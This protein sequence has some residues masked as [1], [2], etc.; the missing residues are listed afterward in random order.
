VSESEAS[1]RAEDEQL[2]PLEQWLELS[3][4]ERQLVAFEI[5]DG[6]VQQATGALMHLQ[7]FRDLHDP[8]S[9]EA[10]KAFDSAIGLLEESLREA[11]RLMA[12][13]RPPVLEEAGVV[14]AMDD[15]VRDANQ[16]EEAQIDFSHAV[17]FDRLSSVL[18]TT[19]FRIAQ[20]G[21]T[22][23]CRHSQSAKV[24]ISLVQD[25]ERIHLEVQDWGVGFDPEAVDP[26]RFGLRGIRERAR[27]LGG[28]A[29][30]ETSPGQGTRLA[31][32]LPL[33]RERD[34]A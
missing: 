14:A 18:E 31:V 6:F 30:I 32:E 8:E 4:G 9:E 20:E 33:E 5:H 11:R 16:R 25:G 27:L 21:L 15:L 13:L 23:A 7:A 17:H 24:Q 10:R 26:S 3:E 29:L 28:R 34:E 1:N 19:I 12:G 2:P 22:N